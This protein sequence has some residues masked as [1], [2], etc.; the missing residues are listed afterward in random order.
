MSATADA[1]IRYLR[2]NALMSMSRNAWRDISDLSALEVG[3][4]VEPKSSQLLI[5]IVHLFHP[6]LH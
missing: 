6:L 1:L 4:E 5:E 2:R 3:R